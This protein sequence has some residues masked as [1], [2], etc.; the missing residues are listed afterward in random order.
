M[1]ASATSVKSHLMSIENK[2]SQPP[3]WAIKFLIWFC[4]DYL[5]E[6][7]LGDLLEQFEEDAGKWGSRKARR[8]FVFRVLRLIHPVTI[9]KRL[10]RRER[11]TVGLMASH[12]KVSFRSMKKYKFYAVVNIAGLALAVAFVFMAYLFI[13]HERSYD[14]F[15]SKKDQT[16]RVYQYKVDAESSELI[17]GSINGCTPIPLLETLSNGASGIVNHTR[18]GSNSATVVKDQVEYDETIAMADEDFFEMFDFPMI[19]GNKHAFK[20]PN[21][22]F[23]S[24]QKAIKYFGEDNPIGQTLEVILGDSS[25]YFQVAGIVDN[26]KSQTSL[27]FDFLV[28]FEHLENHLKN[29]T[30]EQ[31]IHSFKISFIESYVTLDGGSSEDDEALFTKVIGDKMDDRDT[32]GQLGLQ[33]ITSIHFDTQIQGMY[34]AAGEERL[35]LLGGLAILVLV[36]AVINFITLSVGH[37]THRLREVGLRR[38]FGGGGLSLKIQLMIETLLISLVAAIISTVIVLYFVPEFNA[39]TEISLDYEFIF[40][41]L[42]FLI[43]LIFGVSVLTGGIQALVLTGFSTSNAL[44][45]GS[46]QLQKKRAN[47]LVIVFQFAVAVLL[48][49]GTMVIH[50]QMAFIQSKDLGFDKNELIEIG[51]HNAEEIEE[52]RQMARLLETEFQSKPYVLGASIS[53]NSFKDPWTILGFRQEDQSELKAYFN[54][55]DEDYIETMDIEI[56]LGSSFNNEE[57]NLSTDIIVNESMVKMMNWDDPIGKQIPGQN[58]TTR[59]RVVGVVKDFHFGSL[60]ERIQPLILAVDPGSIKSGITGLSTYVWPPN[61]YTMTVRLA[62]GDLVDQVDFLENGWKKIHP[63]KTFNFSFVDDVLASKYAEE[64]RWKKLADFSSLFALGIAWM[65]LLGLTRLSVQRRLKEIS[66]R[67]VLGSTLV[68]V[69]RELSRTYVIL[70]L[71]SCGIMGPLGWWLMQEWLSSFDYRI[72]LSPLTF[73]FASGL[74][75]AIATGS[76]VIQGYRAAMANP[77]DILRAE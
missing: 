38:I 18:L 64:L 6:G 32:K 37:S 67:K 44:K 39:F 76:V 63:D 41:Q 72:D 12:I 47:N 26:K 22:L 17:D 57:T 9:S 61:F 62:P 3:R 28:S 52:A 29:I 71:V 60:H 69:T 43:A 34:P 54:L 30:S 56:V 66:I 53:M 42:G 20:N 21:A 24:E 4:E 5:I 27:K 15:H 19:S 14:Q 31:S 45:G 77:V 23:I 2:S 65:G 50:Q 46:S 11:S 35:W 75:F 55:I 7:I 8:L 1:G 48:V 51:L 25:L 58:F 70:V 74:V 59:H 16:Y 40:S 13:Q 49:F 36:V 33:P 73:L 68:G 10:M